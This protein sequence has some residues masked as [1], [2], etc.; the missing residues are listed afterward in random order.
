M[1]PQVPEP[2]AGRVV[3]VKAETTSKLLASAAVSVA[4]ALLESAGPQVEK[5]VST[6]EIVPELVA[7]TLPVSVGLPLPLT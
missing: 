2:G 4:Q 6:S 3:K 5:I 7:S 1:P